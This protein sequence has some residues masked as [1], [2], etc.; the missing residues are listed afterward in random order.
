MRPTA[1]V[2]EDNPAV[3]EILR[4]GF[5]ARGWTVVEAGDAY[6]GL[7]LFQKH[8]PELVTLDLIMPIN[9][10]MDSVQVARTIAEAYPEVTIFVLSALSAEA[11]VNRFFTDYGIELFDKLSSGNS[12]LSDLLKKADALFIRLTNHSNAD[13]HSNTSEGRTKWIN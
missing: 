5:E 12:A 13:T 3:R 4:A 1:L 6:H 10:G 2:I 7:A 8:L 9:D 11:E